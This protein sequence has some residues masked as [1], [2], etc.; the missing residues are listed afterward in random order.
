MTTA[1][2]LIAD[3]HPPTRTGVRWAL[4]HDGEFAVCA[5]VANATDAVESARKLK[6]EIAL[7][8]IHMPGG[9]INAAAQI[10]EAAPETAVVMLTVSR[11]DADLFAALR[12]GARGYLLKDIDPARLPMA[13]RGVL[14]GEAA[15]PRGLVAHLIDEFRSRDSVSGRRAGLLATLTEREWEVL[16][17]MQE[18]L[19]TTEMAARMFVTPVTVRTHVSAILR[20]LQVSDRAA[21]VRLASR[22]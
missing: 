10:A 14:S 5:E 22:G 8:D 1:R 6:P 18:G 13:L 4:E 19:P 7:L 3:D 21:A 11:D 16:T 15:L 12:A 9:G 20:K 2:V 17:L